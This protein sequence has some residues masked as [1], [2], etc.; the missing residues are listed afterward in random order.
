MKKIIAACLCIAAL[1][2]CSDASN[3]SRVLHSSGYTDVVITGYRWF[4]C[5]QDDEVRTGF[6]ARS[7]AGDIVSGIVC[8]GLFLK[9]ATVR[10]D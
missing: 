1:A 6:T 9:G 3:A 7:P 2:G 4:G 8:Q 5:S 10:L